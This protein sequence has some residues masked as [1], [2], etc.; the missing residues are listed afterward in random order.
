M[1][2]FELR[3]VEEGFALNGGQLEE[4]LLYREKEPDAAS[5]LVGFL[6]QQQGSELQI[7]ARDGA[8]GSKQRRE[9]VMPLGKS[10]LG[11]ALRGESTL[12]AR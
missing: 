6:S 9:P 2:S 7:Y 1:L 10:S 12:R 8:L 11:N 4:P 5:R 3:E